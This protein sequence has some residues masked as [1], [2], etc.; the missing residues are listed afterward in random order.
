[1]ACGNKHYLILYGEGVTLD[2]LLKEA[3]LLAWAHGDGDLPLLWQ[4]ARHDSQP[5]HQEPAAHSQAAA[6]R[7]QPLSPQLQHQGHLEETSAFAGATCDT[8]PVLLL[9]T[10]LGR[11]VNVGQSMYREIKKITLV[12][13]V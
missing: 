2:D 13:Y 11:S 10:A 12:Y 3:L 6:A 1:M 7:L 4:V 9:D 5:Q 8:F